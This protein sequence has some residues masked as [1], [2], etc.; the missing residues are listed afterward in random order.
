MIKR[1]PPQRVEHEAPGAAFAVREARKRY[2]MPAEKEI[3]PMAHAAH[4]T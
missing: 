1:N 2:A 3:R 4:K